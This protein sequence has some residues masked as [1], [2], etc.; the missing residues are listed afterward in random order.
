MKSFGGALVLSIGV[1][2]CSN[3]A[4]LAGVP[5]SP[6]GDAAIARHATTYK[7]LLNFDGV[8]GS[9]PNAALIAVNGVLYGTTYAGGYYNYGTAYSIGTDGKEKVLHSFGGGFDA[10]APEGSLV[11]LNGV[12]YGT[13]YRG[14]ANNDGTVFRVDAAG[15]EK[16]LYS[17]GS[18]RYGSALPDGTES[19][20]ELD[21]AQRYA[22]RHHLPRRS[23]GRR[24]D[25]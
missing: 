17:F 12:L 15:K 4:G 14:G 25:F 21:G 5:T 13:T 16:V 1:V 10:S 24:H 7:S 2:A 3:P 19:G 23:G 20:R 18:L 9:D 11:E 8:N 22:L 6:A